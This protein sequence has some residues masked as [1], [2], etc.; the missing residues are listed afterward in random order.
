MR[1]GP[2]LVA[3]SY[4]KYDCL[5]YRHA[6]GCLL[7]EAL[8]V[9]LQLSPSICALVAVAAMGTSRASKV[10][11]ICH[12]KQSRYV[13]GY[14]C[15]RC[16][17]EHN[18]WAG[19]SAHLRMI[20]DVPGG[21]NPDRLRY[22]ALAKLRRAVAFQETVAEDGSK[23]IQRSTLPALTM[24]VTL[25]DVADFKHQSRVSVTPFWDLHA[26]TACTCSHL[27]SRP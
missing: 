4:N 27:L 16:N 26:A 14:V 1:C 25:R 23:Q 20:Q 5:G 7:F 13:D 3:L 15:T 8:C 6:A 19:L 12:T 2:E 10:V 24:P 17:T 22:E 18:S 11:H 9:A 21:A